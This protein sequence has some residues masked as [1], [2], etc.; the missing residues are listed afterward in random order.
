MTG[1]C[2]STAV[3]LAVGAVALAVLEL[4]AR[5]RWFSKRDT[6]RKTGRRSAD[7]TVLELLDD[8]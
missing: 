2:T 3:T 7:S 6:L 4:N 5:E 8:M 1:T